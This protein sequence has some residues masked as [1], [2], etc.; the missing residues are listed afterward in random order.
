MSARMGG[1]KQQFYIGDTDKFLWTSLMNGGDGIFYTQEMAQ[2][3]TKQSET[4]EPS[5]YTTICQ[6]NHEKCDLDS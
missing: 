4:K 5:N 1:R 3:K 6:N 2:N